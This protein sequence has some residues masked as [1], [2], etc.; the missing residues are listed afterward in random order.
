MSDIQK[1]GWEIASKDVSQEEKLS[2]AYENRES[3]QDR[4]DLQGYYGD[5]DDDDD[6]V[7]ETATPTI[8]TLTA[9]KITPTET[10]TAIIE[11]VNTEKLKES[12]LQAIS[13]IV[14]AGDAAKVGEI[15]SKIKTDLTTTL[16]N[17]DRM[18]GIATENIRNVKTISPEQLQISQTTLDEMTRASSAIKDQLKMVD[19]VALS[20]MLADT[21]KVE[22]LREIGKLDTIQFNI[23]DLPEELIKAAHISENDLATFKTLPA[24]AI[25]DEYLKM[26]SEGKQINLI[27]VKSS[28]EEQTFAYK[29]VGATKGTTTVLLTKEES[30]ALE[31]LLDAK[32]KQSENFQAINY[33]PGE[34]TAKPVVSLTNVAGYQ[35]SNIES[36]KKIATILND[37][38]RYNADIKVFGVDKEGYGTTLLNLTPHITSE[39]QLG[40][41]YGK[42]QPG[43]VINAKTGEI[44]QR[45]VTIGKTSNGIEVT[46]NLVTAPFKIENGKIVV[47]GKE[48]YYPVSANYTKAK[49]YTQQDWTKIVQGAEQW[50]P[51]PLQ[52]IAAW[53]SQSM[54]DTETRWANSGYASKRIIAYNDQN[55]EWSIWNALGFISRELSSA[56]ASTLYGIAPMD[57]D[58]AW[59]G[60]DVTSI[61]SN[62]KKTANKFADEWTRTGK[63]NTK[64]TGLTEYDAQLLVLEAASPDKLKELLS[65]QETSVAKLAY[66][67]FTKAAVIDAIGTEEV[68][69]ITARLSARDKGDVTES[70]MAGAANEIA[71]N[72]RITGTP[73]DIGIAVATLGLGGAIVGVGGKIVGRAESAI[74]GTK[75]VTGAVKDFATYVKDAKIELPTSAG[76]MP[77]DYVL[78]INV[79]GTTLV[80][81]SDTGKIAKQINPKS[82]IADVTKIQRQIDYAETPTQSANVIK[83]LLKEP[84]KSTAALVEMKLTDPLKVRNVFES[85]AIE[86]LDTVSA[87]KAKAMLKDVNAR[88]VKLSLDTIDG[89][90]VEAGGDIQKLAGIMIKESTQE[91]KL[92]SRVVLDQMINTATTHGTEHYTDVLNAAELV[93]K[94]DISR[95]TKIPTG[96]PTGAS[97]A[98]SGIERELTSIMPEWVAREIESV[99]NTSKITGGPLTKIADIEDIAALT[100]D[101]IRYLGDELAYATGGRITRTN[102]EQYI[103]KAIERTKTIADGGIED[104]VPKIV[105]EA[106]ETSTIKGTSPHGISNIMPIETTKKILDYGQK[107]GKQVDTLEKLADKTSDEIQQ[108]AEYTGI[109][110]DELQKYIETAKSSLKELPVN[111]WRIDA[112]KLGI[113]ETNSGWTWDTKKLNALSNEEFSKIMKNQNLGAV[114]NNIPVNQIANANILDARKRKIINTFAEYIKLPEGMDAAQLISKAGIVDVNTAATKA[115]EK[116]ANGDI[117]GAA[118]EIAKGS[119]TS[120]AAISVTQDAVRNLTTQRISRMIDFGAPED[121]VK[122]LLRIKSEQALQDMSKLSKEGKRLAFMMSEGKLTT[123]DR[124]KIWNDP[125]MR[126]LG[127]D[128]GYNEGGNAL[129]VG[130]KQDA[131]AAAKSK[132]T[133]LAKELWSE[134]EEEL[135][136]CIARKECV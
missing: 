64:G 37:D 17:V 26:V 11:A 118:I 108:I 57:V 41:V 86:N 124:L 19:T 90:A 33:T 113:V 83:E 66:D 49:S 109:K 100:G 61:N 92:G 20:R 136:K 94:L 52:P 104:Y 29:Y 65:K 116:L 58:V 4:L 40:R 79:K 80:S 14:R 70:V 121:K 128:A 60:V 21:T 50:V 119:A 56:T 15:A 24:T 105:D 103:G 67:Q 82:D 44:E 107:T 25:I 12:T 18:A 7:I 73:L 1:S 115:I 123:A 8:T 6:R 127:I 31:K 55:Q 36:A 110:L 10:Q 77:L 133:G 62:G 96:V 135:K 132:N 95:A 9:T 81:T 32:K 5:W 85:A 99:V 97:K 35:V 16:E 42:L 63:I 101:K 91:G 122:Q 72:Q 43:Q 54:S 117:M 98:I 125:A 134:L 51:E 129:I 112:E 75:K 88:T 84:E 78:N 131:I 39:D 76:Q 68:N 74:S 27:P 28:T 69:R 59:K 111:A 47:Y 22:V 30:T 87:D 130:L 89:M 106:I 45:K 93:K 13:E 48:Y 102:I 3:I 120:K 53:L 126:Q 46:T 34:Q 114:F 71:V 23:T 38:V 2:A